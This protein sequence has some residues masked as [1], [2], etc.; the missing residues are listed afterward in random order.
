MNE[1]ILKVL[2]DETFKEIY[3]NEKLRNAVAYAHAIAVQMNLICE[4]ISY[5][6]S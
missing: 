2:D 3:N 1:R 6:F 4:N 5:E